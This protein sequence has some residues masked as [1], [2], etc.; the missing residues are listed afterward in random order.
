MTPTR[1][2][3]GITAALAATLLLA[4]CGQSEPEAGTAESQTTAAEGTSPEGDATDDAAATSGTDTPGADSSDSDDSTSGSDAGESTAGAGDG[5]GTD[6]DA[7]EFPRT[8]VV[9]AGANTEEAVVIIEAEPQRIAALTFETTEVVAALGAA[10]RLVM[11]PEA[12][13]NP[14]LGNHLEEVADVQAKNP[15]EAK[16][17]AEAIIATDPDLVLLSARHGLEEGV[18]EALVSAD[19]PVVIVP[20]SWATV[21]DLVA[22]VDLVGTALGLDSEADALAAEIEQGLSPAADA[23]A[24]DAP[25]VLVLSNQAGQ[26]FVVAGSAF[27][28]ELIRLAG[29][30]DAGAALGLRAS[31]PITAEQVIQANPDAIL[32]VDMNGSGPAM[33]ASL[34]ENPA[35]ATLPAVAEDR[36]L[37]LQGRQ[38]QALGLQHTAEGLAAITD[39]LDT[40]R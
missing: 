35:V 20:N 36:V 40:L 13:T 25:T 24:S 31:G 12:V 33:F 11:V 7:G 29:A 21:D 15:V 9:P 8:I 6:A 32:L 38:V 3:T 39:W 23:E 16:T 34:L 10:D 26:P 30:E 4:G 22:N 27:P 37:M 19:I 18:A 17:N 2:L 14:A 1:T 5:D 28:L